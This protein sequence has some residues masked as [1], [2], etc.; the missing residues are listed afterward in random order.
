[1]LKENGFKFID[2]STQDYEIP[3]GHFDYGVFLDGDVNLDGVVNIAD[4]TLIQKYLANKAELDQIQE[5]N[6]LLGDPYKGI[7]INNATRIQKKIVGLDDID[8]SVPKG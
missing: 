1:M 7:T 2:A 8:D 6:A 3:Q 5:C 4:A